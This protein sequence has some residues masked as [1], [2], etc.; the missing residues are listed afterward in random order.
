MA[1]SD[2]LGL[3]GLAVVA[4]FTLFCAQR[5][6]YLSTL[7][8]VAFFLRALAALVNV[9]VVPLPDS[10]ADAITFEKVAWEWAQGGVVEAVRQ[11][12]GPDSYFISW[13]LSILYALMD[14]SLLMAQSVSLLFGMGTVVLGSLLA[15]ELWGKRT[16]IKAGWVLALFPTLILYSALVMR[17]AYIWFFVLVALYAVAFWARDNKLR[18]LFFALS[19]FTGAAFFHGAMFVGAVFF[20]LYVALRA[21]RR[22]FFYLSRSRLQ[23]SSFVLI[24]SVSFSLLYYVGSGVS[25]PKLGTFQQA[26]NTERII[27]IVE[28]RTE[29]S[30]GKLGAS[31]PDWTQPSTDADM[32]VKTPLRMAYFTFSPFPWDVRLPSHLIGMF[33]GIFYLLLFF[34]IWRNRRA[35]WASPA[36]RVILL[37]VIGYILVFSLGTGNFGTGIRHRAKFVAVLIILAAPLLPMFSFRTKHRLFADVLNRSNS[38]SIT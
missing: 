9:Y 26:I 1:L 31:F 37:I 38:K 25:L 29:G 10:T 30:G 16:A 35:I 33:D 6:P 36:T 23:F 2:L 11:F 5:W 22:L 14:R 15:K 20:L 32:L 21:V 28:S 3:T 27:D 34:L 13:L 8:L 18:Y 19:G 7:L 4:C 17:E 24:F 12:T